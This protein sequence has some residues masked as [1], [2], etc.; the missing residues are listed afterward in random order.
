[1]PNV[2]VQTIVNAHRNV[3]TAIKAGRTRAAVHTNSGQSEAIAS[4]S[5]HGSWGRKTR[6]KHSV[7]TIASAKVPS[8][9]SR[10]GGALRKNDAS[11]ITSGATVIVPSVSE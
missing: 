8:A 11:P 9:I 5:V 7:A 3:A 1:M 4:S 6:S 2:V 10:R